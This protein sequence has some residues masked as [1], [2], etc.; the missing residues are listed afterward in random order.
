MVVSSV[1]TAEATRKWRQSLLRWYC[2]LWIYFYIIGL[3]GYRKHA[4]R[5]LSSAQGFLREF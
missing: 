3:Y 5:V 4:V 1:F 2:Q